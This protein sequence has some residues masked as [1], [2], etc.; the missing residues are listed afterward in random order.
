MPGTRLAK[1]PD[2]RVQAKE[3]KPGMR[4]CGC[5][6]HKGKLVPIAEFAI[7][8]KRRGT[9]TSWCI[10]GRRQYQA[11]RY[12][13]SKKLAK[14][15]PVL[16]FILAEDDQHCGQLCEDCKKPC[17]EGERVVASDSLLHHAEH[18]SS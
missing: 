15:G 1:S 2:K 5:P 7:K 16:E 9:L 13:S 11:E 3:P 18:F 10:E 4:R 8:D 6:I 17:K 14:L 12:L